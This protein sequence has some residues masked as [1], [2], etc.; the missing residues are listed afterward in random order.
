MIENLAQHRTLIDRQA[1]LSEIEEA[2]VHRTKVSAAFA[3]TLARDDQYRLESV[4]KWLN[5]TSYANDHDEHCRVRA[6]S[7]G[8]GQW[9]LENDSFKNWL[10]PKFAS[11]P[12][13]LWLKGDPGAGR[14]TKVISNG[15]C[16]LKSV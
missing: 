12:P 9:F 6:T 11:I 14:S 1:A 4:K 15:V 10:D 13:L 8:S 2:R 3:T 5:P 16:L 7:P